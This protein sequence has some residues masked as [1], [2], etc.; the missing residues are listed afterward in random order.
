MNMQM[1]KSASVFPNY[2]FS[3]RFTWFTRKS[4]AG[5]RSQ[6]LSQGNDSAFSTSRFLRPNFLVRPLDPISYHRTTSAKWN[7]SSLFLLSLTTTGWLALY[8]IKHIY[9]DHIGYLMNILAVGG[10][11]NAVDIF[12]I[13]QAELNSHNISVKGF[14]VEDLTRVLSP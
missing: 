13:Q 10:L 2:R 7:S 9:Y 8:V 14:C 1:R 4:V 3:Q 12:V 6:Y 11:Q 5:K